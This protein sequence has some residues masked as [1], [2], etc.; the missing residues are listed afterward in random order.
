MTARGSRQ[1]D[2]A[3]RHRAI[4]RQVVRNEKPPSALQEFRSKKVGDHEL[5]SDFEKLSILAQAG[6]LGR[7]DT[8]YVSPDASS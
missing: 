3:G 5:I 6:V 8:L 2:L 7:L 1:R 4:Y